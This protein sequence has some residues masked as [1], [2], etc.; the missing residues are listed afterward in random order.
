MPRVNPEDLDSILAEAGVGPRTAKKLRDAN[1]AAP[2]EES[3]GAR[4]GRVKGHGAAPQPITPI[5]GI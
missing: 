2:S 1:N 3:D 4:S 5:E